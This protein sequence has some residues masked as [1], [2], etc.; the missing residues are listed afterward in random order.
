MVIDDDEAVICH[1]R[2]TRPPSMS[3]PACRHPIN[4]QA[5]GNLAVFS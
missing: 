4:E 5:T 2:V 3:E 1:A